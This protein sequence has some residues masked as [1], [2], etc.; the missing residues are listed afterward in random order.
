M[1]KTLLF[2]LFLVTPNDAE[3]KKE[4][5]PAV[6]NSLDNTQALYKECGLEG[7]LS[8]DAFQKSMDGYHKY[9]P[10]K[11]ILAI[12]D[13]SKPS[14]QKRFFVIDL[15]A[16]KILSCTYVAHG[17]NSGDLMATNFSNTPESLKSSLG[18]FRIG[19]TI[20]TIKHGTSLILDGLEKGKNDNARM[21]E[22]IMHGASYVCEQFVKQYG[23]TGKSFGCPALPQD[24]MRKMMPVLA[25]GSLLFIYAK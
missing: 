20:E 6:N 25:N 21:R 19:S 13:F 24:V 15:D 5:V 3:V 8:F 17:K 14:S 18:F 22:I 10:Q 7:Q 12:C 9:K 16:K 1:L 2:L 11:H 4:I 23:Y